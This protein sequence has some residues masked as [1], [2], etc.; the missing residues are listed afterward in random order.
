MNAEEFLTH[1]GVK[2]MHWGVRKEEG[3]TSRAAAKTKRAKPAK[4]HSEDAAAYKALKL[5][6]QTHGLSSLTNNE[7]R[8]LTARFDLEQKYSKMNEV[9][10]GRGKKYAKGFL[11]K[12]GKKHVDKLAGAAAAIVVGKALTEIA[13]NP[14]T[15]SAVT[16][17]LSKVV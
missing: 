10:T 8:T 4:L 2:G 6:A 13:T 11:K 16:D 17:L 7:V 14:K 5:K 12:V 3:G 1:H 9:Q 15:S